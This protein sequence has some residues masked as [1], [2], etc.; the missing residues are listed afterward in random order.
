MA[1]AAR[2]PHPRL[3]RASMIVTPRENGLSIGRLAALSGVKIET[4]RYYE[5]IGLLSEASRTSGGR[6]QFGEDDVRALSFVRR[7]RELG[8]SLDEI[9]SLLQLALSQASC[10][11]FKQVA[12]LRLEEVRARMR[13]L[14]KI[15]RA[16]DVTIGRCAG[17]DG[18]H[19]AILDALEGD[20]P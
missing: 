9:R 15:E 16:L 11:Q 7:A 17:D 3:H 6:R 1:D 12:E 14:G 10:R 19:C 20:R 5:R 8:F 4:I 18:P 13:D 2:A